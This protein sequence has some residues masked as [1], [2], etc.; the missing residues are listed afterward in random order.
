MHPSS[1]T[2]ST[3]LP[4]SASSLGSPRS[5]DNLVYEA[6]TVA[7]MLLLLVSLWAF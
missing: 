3:P 5:A 6:V 4:R 7:A 2:A 1:L